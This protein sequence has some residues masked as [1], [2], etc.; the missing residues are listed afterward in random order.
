MASHR[1]AHKLNDFNIS[2]LPRLISNI[3]RTLTGIEIHPGAKIG[4]NVFFDHTGAIVE[5]TA[6]IGN[7]VTIIGRVC[8]G[9]TGK[10]KGLRHIKFFTIA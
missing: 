4:K 1:V 7:N 10:E 2:V 6:E 3:S 8:L 5:E 9:A